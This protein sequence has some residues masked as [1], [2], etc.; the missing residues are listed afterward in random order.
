[1]I[2]RFPRANPRNLLSLAWLDV[3]EHDSSSTPGVTRGALPASEDKDSI[4]SRITLRGQIS[5]FI[6]QK[7]RFFVQI[8]TL[9]FQPYY[10]SR[11]GQVRLF[12]D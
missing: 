9:L 11:N 8:D 6:K 2:H 5:G 1:M 4:T 7:S 12:S 3:L 10:E